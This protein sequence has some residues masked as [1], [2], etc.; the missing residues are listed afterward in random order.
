M[1]ELFVLGEL[2]D[3]P[4]HGYLLRDIVNLAFGPARRISWGSLYP[5][6]RRLEANGFITQTA[7]P[8][9][10]AKAR[11]KT[12]AITDEGRER[13]YFLMLKPEEFTGD[14]PELFTV[15]FVNS[16]RLTPDQRKDFLLHYRSYLRF[17]EGQLADSTRFIETQEGIPEAERTLILLTIDRQRQLNGA[18]S[19]WLEQQLTRFSKD[20]SEATPPNDH[21][22]TERDP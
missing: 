6:I 10:P 8:D 20:A 4:L 1:Y 16:D 3:Q 2:L 5:L 15:K 12:Y 9:G 18:E 7:E 11:R 17:V 14:Y 13:F 21:E 19:A 22:R